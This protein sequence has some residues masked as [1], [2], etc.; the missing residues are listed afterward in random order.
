MKK[1]FWSFFEIF[2]TVIIAVVAVVLIRTFVTQPFLVSGSSMEPSFENG[3][4]LLRFKD[5]VTGEN[6]VFDPGSNT[7]GLT[8]EGACHELHS[9]TSKRSAGKPGCPSRLRQKQTHGQRKWPQGYMPTRF[10][11]PLYTSCPTD[12]SWHRTLP[13]WLVAWG[14]GG[15]GRHPL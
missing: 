6:G 12:P 5:D 13:R 8:M 11:C 9:P 14:R 15:R 1:I 4:Y 2:E 3:N 7:V 10:V